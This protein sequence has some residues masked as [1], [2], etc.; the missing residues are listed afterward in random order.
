MSDWQPDPAL[1]Q[2]NYS[3]VKTLTLN[4]KGYKWIVLLRCLGWFFFFTVFVNMG[5]QPVPEEPKIDHKIL[6]Y[7]ER[8]PSGYEEWNG[9][10]AE[11]VPDQSIWE[12]GTK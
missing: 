6:T 8:H 1:T 2:T 5:R 4:D 3:H 12:K 7:D 9:Q 11:A 10:K